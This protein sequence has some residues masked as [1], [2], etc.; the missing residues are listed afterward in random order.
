MKSRLLLCLFI[1]VCIIA[2]PVFSDSDDLLGENIDIDSIFEEDEETEGLEDEEE[3]AG[4][5]SGEPSDEEE[6]PEEEKSLLERVVQKADFTFEGNFRFLTG[7]VPGFSY[8]T[9]EG[10]ASETLRYNDSAAFKVSSVLSLDFRVSPE[11]RVF[12]KYSLTFP[13]FTPEV[14][15]L[16]CDYSILNAVFFRIGRHRVTW[17]QSRNFS[18]TNLPNRVP[19]GYVPELDV[20]D[21]YAMKI[22][23]PVGIGGVE[24]LVHTRR[25]YFENPNAPGIDEIGFGGNLNLAVKYFDLTGGIFY[26]KLLN[27]RAYGSFKTTLFGRLELYAEGLIAHDLDYIDPTGEE[28]VPVEEDVRV[29]NQT[30]LSVNVGFFIDFFSQNLELNGEY[31]FNGEESELQVKYTTFPLFY[32]HNIAANFSLKLF[33]KKFRLFTQF[34]YN[35]NEKSG[36]II[37]GFILDILPNCDITLAVPIILGSTEGGYFLENPDPENRPL[38]LVFSIVLSGKK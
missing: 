22:N 32:G 26:H 23:V 10:D 20:A 5:P 16:F 7:Y 21:S 6:E 31:F 19:D 2:Q 27:L 36:L 29:D 34:K 11:F 4:K 13:D 38:S 3:P 18:F 15:E 14:T 17:G 37:P 25:G 24:A 9:P 1:F 8:T 30:D 35:F 33:E 28:E 12:Q